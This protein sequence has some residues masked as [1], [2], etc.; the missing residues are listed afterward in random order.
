MRYDRT[1][2]PEVFGGFLWHEDTKRDRNVWAKRGS[3]GVWRQV[4]TRQDVPHA[5]P[6]ITHVER[7][8]LRERWPHSAW[9]VPNEAAPE[10]EAESALRQEQHPCHEAVKGRSGQS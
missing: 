6:K 5:M 4:R 3:D 7:Q 2:L 10:P 8:T 9:P 1:G